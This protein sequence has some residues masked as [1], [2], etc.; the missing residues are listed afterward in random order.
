[1]GALDHR[2]P[3]ETARPP[4]NLWRIGLVAVAAAIA[5]AAFGIYQRRTHE[6]GVKQWT[7]EQAIPTVA[8][9][10]PHVGAATQRLVLPGTVQAWYETPIY[11]GVTGYLKSWHFDYGAHVK[12]G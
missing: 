6:A 9:I 4:Q 10:S 7:K 12:K 8:V 11:A 3:Q 5:I 2:H 1:M